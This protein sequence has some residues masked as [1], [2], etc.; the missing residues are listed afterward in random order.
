MTRIGFHASHEQLPPSELLELVQRA[1]CC[2]FYDAD[3]WQDMW[4]M[5]RII[6]NDEEAAIRFV[7]LNMMAEAE[8]KTGVSP[9][10]LGQKPH[11]AVLHD[12]PLAP[13]LLIGGE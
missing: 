10:N 3:R 6:H 1:Q 4:E 12:S 2:G 8:K 5:W 11:D 13:V 9:A 7:A